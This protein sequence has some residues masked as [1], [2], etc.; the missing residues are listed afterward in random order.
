MAYA[1]TVA[2]EDIIITDDDGPEVD[3]KPAARPSKGKMSKKD[4][5]SLVFNRATSARNYVEGNLRAERAQATD[6]YKGRLPDV[7]GEEVKED[8]SR[9]VL[10]EVRD[11]VLGM[12]PDLMRVFFSSSE[13]VV[14]YKPVV[15]EDPEQFKRNQQEARQATE[16]VRNTVLG[17]DNPDFF[18][19]MYDAFKDA[20]VRK[21]GFVKWY[22]EESKKPEYSYYTDLTEEVAMA[23]AADDEVEI[24]EKSTRVVTPPVPAP[25]MMMMTPPMMAEA[26]APPQPYVVY[27][28]QIKKVCDYGKI[29]IC[30]VPCEN[31]IVSDEGRSPDDTPLIGYVN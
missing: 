7:D 18:V 12:I 2:P 9:A 21:T 1:E 29:K 24:V 25:S 14:E 17:T 3:D 19:T 26:P 23:L 6:Y 27:D 16:F 15:V 10:S 13:G 30:G 4:F 5:Q 11:T 31:M 28:V 22:W 20:L 8:R